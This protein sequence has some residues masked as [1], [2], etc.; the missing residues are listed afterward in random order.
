MAGQHWRY[1]VEHFNAI[2]FDPSLQCFVLDAVSTS[3]SAYAA[4]LDTVAQNAT[5]KVACF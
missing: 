3:A 2:E 4:L 5:T 1:F